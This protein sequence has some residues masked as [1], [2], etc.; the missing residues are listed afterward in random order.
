MLVSLT[1]L[2]AAEPAD[3]SCEASWLTELQRLVEV[4]E[5]TKLAAGGDEWGGDLGAATE[6]LAAALSEAVMRAKPSD[7][8][9]GDE[10][11][12]VL[13]GGPGFAAADT[14]G[15]RL[16]V[17]FVPIEASTSSRCCAAGRTLVRDEGG[18]LMAVVTDG[19]ACDPD[20]LRQAATA[21]H[22]DKRASLRGAPA[23]SAPVPWG[24][25]ALIEECAEPVA[26][27]FNL[28]FDRGAA[29]AARGV[30]GIHNF[31]VLAR[32][33]ARQV[34]CSS[35]RTATSFFPPAAAPPFSPD[36]AARAFAWQTAAQLAPHIDSP[37]RLGYE[38]QCEE[39][40]EACLDALEA[41]ARARSRRLLT[42]AS[43]V[44][45]SRSRSRRSFSPPLLLPHP[46]PS[47]LLPRPLLRLPLHC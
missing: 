24:I 15:E 8:S 39:E 18:A 32:P 25:T 10:Q 29:S 14:A 41:P 38:A 43:S 45:C 3:D 27:L 26:R 36:G 46:P 16:H 30:S 13:T 5:T 44:P 21:S 11:P 35:C 12:P 23:L 20:A 17:E 1:L 47:V 2:A 40:T 7:A 6:Q 33:M 37:M 42:F 4:G 19:F 9:G 34:G 22:W 28:T 31:R